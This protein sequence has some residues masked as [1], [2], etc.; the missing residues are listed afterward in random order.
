[1]SDFTSVW[2]EAGH[3][4]EADAH[5]H[6]LAMAKAESM[7]VWPFLAM[8][9]DSAEFDQRLG[10]AGDTI[11]AAASAHG[12]SVEALGEVYHREF[13][14]LTEA[15]RVTAGKVPDAFKEHQFTKADA[16]DADEEGVEKEAG[17]MMNM[18]DR[19][20]RAL[21]PSPV[22]SERDLLP[23]SEETMNAQ[24]E[25]FDSARKANEGDLAASHQRHQDQLNTTDADWADELNKHAAGGYDQQSGQ[26]PAQ[27]D[28]ENQNGINRVGPDGTV[29]GAGD[30]GE[31]ETDERTSDER[32][33]DAGNYYNEN[34]PGDIT[35]KYYN[36]FSSLKTAL[37]EGEDPLLWIEQEGGGQGQPEKPVEAGIEAAGVDPN[38]QATA[39][40]HPFA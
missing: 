20:H 37:E 7:S 24:F 25:K 5:M 12:V 36:K 35:D 9:Q 3:S 11:T 22:A 23:R 39:S 33:R 14:L 8:A 15:R 26:T 27:S 29:Q 16:E 31:Q 21:S 18:M 38:A 34:T 40:R 13:G 4:A 6:A 17:V 2:D 32:Y 30:G 28:W 19:A 10:L 1:M